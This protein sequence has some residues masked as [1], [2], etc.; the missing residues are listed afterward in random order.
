VRNGNENPEVALQDA[1]RFDESAQRRKVER[2]GLICLKPSK[3]HGPVD[4]VRR[5]PGRSAA[6]SCKAGRT[7]SGRRPATA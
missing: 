5:S 2:P 1:E 7:S 3:F 4:R 6:S